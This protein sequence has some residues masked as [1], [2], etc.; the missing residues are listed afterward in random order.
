M[1]RFQHSHHVLF[2][3]RAGIVL[4][5]FVMAWLP[6][7]AQD[8]Q[9]IAALVNDQVIS[10]YDLEQRVRLVVATSGLN[11]TPEALERV[12]EQV[13][14]T[15]VDEELQLQEA[16]EAE[17]AVSDQEVNQAITRLAARNNLSR[18]QI[19]GILSQSGVDENTLR[20]QISASI[21]W[22]TLTQG[23]FGSRINVGEDEVD[24]MLEQLAASSD[25]PQYRLLELFMGVGSPEE[26]ESVRRAALR[27][28]DQLRQGEANFADLARQF[29]QSPSAGAGGDV[30]W[31]TAEELPTELAETLADMRPG[32][33]SPPIRTIGG[34]YIIVL[35]DRRIGHGARPDQIKMRVKQLVVPAFESFPG[36]IIQQAAQA[37]TGISTRRIPCE[38]LD[39]IGAEAKDLRYADLG[40]RLASDFTPQFQQALSGLTAGDST[41]PVRSEVGFHILFVC[42]HEIMGSL[43]PPRDAIEDRLFQQQMSMVQRRFLRDLRRDATVEIR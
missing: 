22:D 32:T 3:V 7:R 41:Q 42:S 18:E 43:L 12:R 36:P 17:L 38:E 24:E 37:A 27:F 29:S 2:G 20:R 34:Y 25:K 39:K 16:A 13:L 21:A 28:V 19:I 5:A 9:R 26:D 8:V 30:G 31:V 33:L 35:R 14:R 11:P 6:A 15:L 23:R 4:L 40:N 1:V 10:A